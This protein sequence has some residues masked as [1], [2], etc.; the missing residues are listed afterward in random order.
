MY[1]CVK[2]DGVYV[3]TNELGMIDTNQFIVFE[4]PEDYE[5]PADSLP[6]VVD[7]ALEWVKNVSKNANAVEEASRF[8][9][10]EID[11]I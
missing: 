9:K 3:T 4:V 1:I 11:R 2:N 7:G 8:L 6:T 10:D 5:I